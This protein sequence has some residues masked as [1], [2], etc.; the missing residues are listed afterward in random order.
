MYELGGGSAAV[1]ARQEAPQTW[2]QQQQHQE[3]PRPPTMTLD[4]RVSSGTGGASLAQSLTMAMR[5]GGAEESVVERAALEATAAR[6]RAGSAI[7]D[8]FPFPCEYVL[9]SFCH[10]WWSFCGGAVLWIVARCFL[11]FFCIVFC[12]PPS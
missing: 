4:G 12:N 8:P 9:P 3:D 6:L 2:Q 5:D 1:G 11:S 10:H 7:S